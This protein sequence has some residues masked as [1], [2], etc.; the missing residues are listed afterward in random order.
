MKS[1]SPPSWESFKFDFSGAE[2]DPRALCTDPQDVAAICA[3]SSIQ[4]KWIDLGSGFGHTVLTYAQLFPGRLA[5][6]LELDSSRV[7]ASRNSALSHHLTNAEFLTHNL[8]TDPLPVGENYFLYFPQGHVLDR[9]LSELARVRAFNLIVIESNGDLFPRLD[10]EEWLT[11]EREIPLS[12]KRHSPCARIYRPNEK[13]RELAGLHRYSFQEKYFLIADGESSWLGNSFGLY[14]SGDQY[15]LAQPPRTVRED[16]V[17]K[18]MTRD[19]LDLK[20]GFLIALR[21]YENVT[22]SVWERIYQGPL[23]KILMTPTFSVEFPGGERVE[24]KD[25]D[26]IKQDNILCYES[27]RDFFFLPRVP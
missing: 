16:Q 2:I 27:S 19:E 8:L 9:I 12:G 7:N 3:D 18:I 14:A 10:R 13:A 24:W 21:E 11:I 15:T 4:G 23:R 5:L 25:I 17:V 20:T 1:S 6:G 26:W 22:V